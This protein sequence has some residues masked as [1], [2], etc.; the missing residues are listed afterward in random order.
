MNK[1]LTTFVLD[2]GGRYGIHPTWKKY[3]AKI[4]YFMFEPD[5]VEAERLKNKYKIKKDEIT[6]INKAL[7][8]KERKLNLSLFKNRAMSSST[9]RKPISP[10]FLNEE[11][12][13]EVEIDN[14]IEVDA[15]TVD[16][17]CKNNDLKLDFMKLDTEG[18][19]YEILEGAINQIKG[20]LLGVRSEVN[21]D[22]VFEGK[23]LFGKL[24]ELML[25]NDYYLLNLDY[26][27][28]GDY[29]NKFVGV[30]GRYGILISTDAV[31]LKRFE[32]LFDNLIG[33][34]NSIEEQIFKYSA[35]CFNN[36]ASDIAIHVMLK[37]RR[38]YGLS[39]NKIKGS[40][41]YEYVDIETHRLFYNL[42]WQ[43]GQ[44]LNDNYKIYKEIFD[45]E[46]L[47]TNQYMES[48]I[49]NPD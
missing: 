18:T 3:K 7:S 35:F 47:K 36:Y 22:Y 17:Y 46:M 2:A 24:N 49:L 26:T 39:Y 6:V 10:F 15:I 42:K 44:S 31:W 12:E 13:G 48:L 38:E 25:D 41:L 28:K 34:N 8:N 5:K 29:Q 9:K 33:S 11:R 19:E 23:P 14:I 43:P 40:S 27:G 45:N 20:S 16:S 32:N 1:K 30:A 21:F 4:S 37:G